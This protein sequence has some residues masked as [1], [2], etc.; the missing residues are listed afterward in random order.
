MRGPHPW[1][2]VKI[3]DKRKKGR[4]EGVH[5]PFLRSNLTFSKCKMIAS[6]CVYTLSGIR[7]WSLITGRGG[8]GG[9]KTG[10]GGRM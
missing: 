1:R 10:G 6:K 3:K 5:H 9:Y 4:G 8:G 7:D 2:P